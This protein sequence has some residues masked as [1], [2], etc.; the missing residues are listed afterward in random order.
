MNQAKKQR[1][2]IGITTAG[3]TKQDELTL[4]NEY[5]EA[6]VNAGGIPYLLPPTQLSGRDTLAQLHGVIISGGGDIDPSCYGGQAH[7]T[8]Y[9]IDKQRDAS[10]L[11]IARYAIQSGLPTLGIC[12]GAQVINIAEGGTLYEHLPDVVG[13]VVLHRLP[14]RE[15]ALHHIR[16]ETH[17][18]LAT[19]LG[20]LSFDASSWHHQGIRTLATSCQATAYA[21]DKVIEAFEMSAHPWLIAVQ[22]HPEH[23]AKEDPIQQRLFNEFIKACKE[24]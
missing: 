13:E 5:V 12:R 4:P 14:P 23:T 7:E 10:D 16:V 21:P 8:L 19:V 1:P 6:V 11:A 24:I 18:R 3:R 22:W 9:N 17:S 15:P 2:L 20:T